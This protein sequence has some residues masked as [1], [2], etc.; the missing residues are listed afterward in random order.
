MQDW[1]PLAT[2]APDFRA[3]VHYAPGNRGR[4]AVCLHIAEGGYVSS[5]NYLRAK[6]LSSHFMISEGGSITQMVPMSASAYANG[7][8]WNDA[9]DVWISPRDKVVAPTWRRITPPINPN[10]QTISIEH[11]GFTSKPRPAAQMQA[12]IKLLRWIAAQYPSLSPYVPDYTLI[13]HFNL[14]TI[15]RVNCPGMYFD[16]GVI[17]AQANATIGAYR[18]KDY[19][20][21]L[22]SNDV[23]VA[24]LAPSAGAWHLFKPGDVV[25]VD[26]VTGGMA[27]IARGTSGGVEV[28]PVGFVPVAVLEAV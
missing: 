12:T 20:P 25:D 9:R 14:D 22:S 3:G 10:L 24:H 27:H 13:G 1:Y 23:R 19:Q 21:A 5:I 7:L 26:D 15:D 4:L 28:G 2:R 18:F 8:S 17:A 16:F 6:G 11:A